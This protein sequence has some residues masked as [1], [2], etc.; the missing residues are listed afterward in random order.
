MKKL[1]LLMLALS[2]TNFVFA[3]DDWGG[4]SPFQR[5]FTKNGIAIC[6]FA[7][8]PWPTYSSRTT[9]LP[10]KKQTDDAELLVTAAVQASIEKQNLNAKASSRP[11]TP[12]RP[13]TPCESLHMIQKTKT[14]SVAGKAGSKERK[15]SSTRC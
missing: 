8:V 14:V 11:S 15:T 4:E 6:F 13:T 1:L 3:M 10:T 2:V 9:S 5:T 7:P 12:A